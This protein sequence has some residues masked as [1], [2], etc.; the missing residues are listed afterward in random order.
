MTE[1]E[2]LAGRSVLVTGATGIVGSWLV[3]SLIGVGAHVVALV[4]DRDPRSEFFRSGVDRTVIQVPGDLTDLP[5]LERALGQYQPSVVYHLAAQTQ[6]RH[7]QRHPL[8]TFESN[9]RGT[10]H[11]LEA[12]RRSSTG[13]DAVVV[14]S[15]DK[16][17]GPA[18]TLPYT[19][20]HALVGRNIYD[21]SKSITDMLAAS[22]SASFDLPIAIV[23]C[24]NTYGGGDLNW[25]RIV[26]GTI[27]SI[28]RGARPIIRSDGTPRRDYV[29]VD[30]A[31]RGYLALTTALLQGRERG[32]AFNL[33]SNDPVAVVDLVREIGQVMQRPE[34]EP[35]VQSAAPNELADQWLD[36]S[37]AAARLDWTPQVARID[38]LRRTIDW[39]RD[40]L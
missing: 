27:R 39:Y 11:L 18:V 21:A 5:L 12:V 32:E 7:A 6:V 14:A 20:S 36:S 2:A 28:C 8:D 30:D 19:E 38:G 35:I 25:D 4:R 24:A 16:A 34:L 29:H 3:R 26:P 15:S 17:Y 40:I 23:R 33:G 9:V 31:V 37:K 10:Y 13:I 1:A 22:Y